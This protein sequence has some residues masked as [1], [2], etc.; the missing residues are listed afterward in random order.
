LVSTK[1]PTGASDEDRDEAL[2]DLRECLLRHRE[3]GTI[4]AFRNEAN[5]ILAD[6]AERL[7]EE[8]DERDWER[9]M[10]PR[11]A[12]WMMRLPPR[13]DPRSKEEAK[14]ALESAYSDA[15]PDL[16]EFDEKAKIVVEQFAP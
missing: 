16:V 11:V 3:T 1:L 10:T 8:Q 14:E 12:R 7:W 5:E 4:E 6:H 2:E 9:N 13:I 15:A